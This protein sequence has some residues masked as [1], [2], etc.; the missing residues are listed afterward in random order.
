MEC[1]GPATK[2]LTHSFTNLTF[3]LINATNPSCCWTTQIDFIDTSNFK[4]LREHDHWSNVFSTKTE[5]HWESVSKLWTQEQRSV[6]QPSK[7]IC[8]H[9]LAQ[10]Q[11]YS[12]KFW[13]DSVRDWLPGQA[14]ANSEGC[15]GLNEENNPAKG[16]S[17]SQLPW[18]T[19]DKSSLIFWVLYFF[20]LTYL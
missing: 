4:F 6:R 11:N 9:L 1:H 12:N 5:L 8:R 15:K 7:S 3:R 18:K 20:F 2:S 16:V 14:D 17:V 13:V 10:L 19:T